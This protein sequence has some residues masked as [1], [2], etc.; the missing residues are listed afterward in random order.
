MN[1]GI[2]G[3][4]FNPVHKGH[5]NASLRFYDEAK[6]DM[7]LVIP[8]RIPPH[9]EGLVADAADRLAMLRLVYDDKTIVGERNI[10]ISDTEL[11]REGKSY[12]IV[13]LREL[14]QQYPDAKL[15]LYTGSDMFYTLE[16]WKEG[17][18]ILR[19]C[20]VY[21]CAREMNER[22]KLEEFA[23]SYKTKYDTECIISESDPLIM[24]STMIRNG[25]SGKTD[26]KSYNFTNSLLTDSVK[27]YI[28]KRGLYSNNLERDIDETTENVRSDLKQLVSSKRLSHIFAVC[29]TAELLADHFASLGADIDKKKVTLA[30]LLH[31]ITKCMDQEALCKRFGIVLS[32]DDISSMQTV[33]AITGAYYAKNTYGINDEIFAAIE[34]HT[35]GSEDMTLLQKIVF[36]SD[37]CEE[38]RKHEQCIISR[39]M[40]LQAINKKDSLTES[41]TLNDAVRDLDYITADILG[42]TVKY[43]RDSGSP[44]HNKTMQSFMYIVSHYEKDGAFGALVGKYMQ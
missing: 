31:D 40:L 7:L 38:T 23:S 28:I 29:E 37:Y 43:L 2:F 27:E 3:G 16:S 26:K 34:S 39:K 1:L 41:Y 30:S 44:V 20:T 9:K 21:V 6:L 25:I 35:V 11:K 22:E 10:T 5:I 12:T 42:K 24:S 8:D 19:M 36:I 14:R 13:T 32:Q 33:H 17:H 4:T 18:S 15:F